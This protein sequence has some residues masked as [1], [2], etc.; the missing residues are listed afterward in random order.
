MHKR[1][2]RTKSP[3]KI[4]L[5]RCYQNIFF[6]LGVVM[7]YTPFYFVNFCL[8]QI[9]CSVQVFFEFTYT[10]KVLL[11]LITKGA[12]Y[13][14]AV[15][16]MLLMLA[17]ILIKLAW[18]AWIENVATPRAQEILHRKLRMQLY[19]KAVGLDLEQYDNPEYY[20]EFVWSINEAATR[21]DA[22]LQDFGKTLGQVAQ[23]LANGVFFL[24]LDAFGIVFILASLAITTLAQSYIG[25]VQF[26]RDAKLKPIERKRS[27]FN[28]IFYLNDYAKEIRLNPVAGQLKEEFT[29]TN[30]RVYP[31]VKQYGRKNAVANLIGSLGSNDIL[32]NTI[33]LGYLVYQ[34]VAKK[35]LSYGSAMAL[36]NASSSFKNALGNLATMI[37][38][39]EQ[40]G[41]Y[42]EKIR[43]FLAYES[44]MPDGELKPEEPFRELTMENVSFAYGKDADT[45]HDINL[46]I[47]TGEKIAIVGYNGA[48]KSTLIKLLLRL[49]DVSRG[50]IRLNGHDIKE[51]DKKS[52]RTLFAAVFQDYKIFASTIADNVKMD[53]A[54]EADQTRIKRAL[55]QSGFE[56][57]LATLP[58]GIDTPLTREFDE[59]GI[60]LSG[61]EAQKVTIARTFYKYCPVIILDEPSSALDPISEYQ[62]NQ[63]MMD[64]AKDKAVIYISHRLS[65][66]VMADRIYMLEQGRIIETGSHKELMELNGKYAQMF[67]MQAEK[68]VP[69]AFE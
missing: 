55:S 33:Y 57:R 16:Y 53:V 52:Y 1:N 45:L 59:R 22:I 12:A 3:G 37:P 17:L 2:K 40:H 6:M 66:T 15:T 5:L 26:A 65:S 54:G 31:I 14:T 32:I 13:Q 49:Y 11:D 69:P 27:Y 21:M 4:G 25:R 30:E 44:N 60:N 63:T 51:Y 20:N 42:V 24:S 48:G 19:Q 62:L 67:K 56:E 61:G 7:R 29:E 34:T 58:E 43:T 23:I 8:Y 47:K 46:S 10:L 36:F 18:A 68:Y 41:L 35:L 39:F 9:Y 50:N 28:R 38:K 64:A